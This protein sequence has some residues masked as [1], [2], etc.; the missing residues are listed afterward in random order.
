MKKSFI[1]VTLLLALTLSACKTSNL[2]NT[3]DMMANIKKDNIE[4]I[5]LS[6]LNDPKVSK[7]NQIIDFSLKIFRDSYDNENI[8]ISPLSI[9]SALG[10]V[11]N[12]A[13][14]ETLSELES[15]FDS[16][17]KG[18][19]EY[20]KAYAQYLPS[21]DK[22]KVSLANSI[23]FK[24]K[25]SLTIDND[26]L[27]TNK[28]YYDASIY[29]APFD[30]STK[31]AINAWVNNMTSGMI[32]KLLEEAPSLDTVMY[33]IN[34][35][36]FDAGWETVYKQIQVTEG[37]F[38]SEN[39]KKQAAKFMNSNEYTFIEDNSV[40]G[41]IKPYKDNKYAFVALLPKD[42]ISMRELLDYLNAKNIMSLIENK[43]SETVLTKLPKFSFEYNKMLNEPLKKMGIIDAFDEQKADFLKL[44][45]SLD[46][47]IF[48]NRV[49]H[50]TK[51][52]VNEKG[53]QAGAVTA[54]EMDATGVIIET[55]EVILDR[56]FFYMIID[57]EQNLPL[58]IGSL[59][60]VN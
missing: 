23:W 55:K 8:L 4:T 15:T 41:V 30:E 12:G 45:K 48:I 2:K 56:P 16:D 46:G 28:D 18:L 31:N 29:K 39:G 3:T 37:E 60:D 43:A 21:S 53:T 19:N 57:T 7:R 25:E 36:S 58:F 26:F 17:I 35:L 20:L 24:D 11:S 40:T 49:I 52:D 32:D 38:V 27:Q 51:I 13:N 59:M 44:G 6:D 9:I 1:I 10:M 54:V 33:L 50:K 34:A 42:N 22:Y 5:K 14:G 47:N